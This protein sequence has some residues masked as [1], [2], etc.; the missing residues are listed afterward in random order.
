MLKGGGCSKEFKG[1]NEPPRGK[2]RG[3]FK[4]KIHN[5]AASCGELDSKRD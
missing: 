3:I 4:C 5:N 2:P 1:T